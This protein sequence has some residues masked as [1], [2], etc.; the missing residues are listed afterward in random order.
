[1][2]AEKAHMENSFQYFENALRHA[3]IANDVA[4][5][6]V[7]YPYYKSNC[8]N[9][10]INSRRL[11]AESKY[12]HQD[13]AEQRRYCLTRLVDML[14]F[15]IKSSSFRS[16]L[17][18]I[19]KEDATGVMHM[20]NSCGN[21]LIED[22][23]YLSLDAPLQVLRQLL[24]KYSSLE[25]SFEDASEIFQHR[26]DD[27]ESRLDN[28]L[29]IC[30]MHGNVD[31]LRSIFSI[32]SDGNPFQVKKW[33]WS[34]GLKGI[35]YTIGHRKFR[36]SPIMAAVKGRLCDTGRPHFKLENLR[37][38]QYLLATSEFTPLINF[39]E[40]VRFVGQS[41]GEFQTPLMVAVDHRDLEA[42][43]ALLETGADPLAEAPEIC[44]SAF[45]ERIFLF[46][47][48]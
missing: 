39:P 42:V 1:M 21:L 46:S 19:S 26:S 6:S 24:T 30:A 33:G 17:F 29:S 44:M 3:V 45:H 5:M 38:L 32:V 7:I 28:I 14:S 9:P 4:V 18:L 35:F 36:S 43:D 20:K 13:K 16:L 2:C 27:N 47:L 25:I 31:C 48:R 40:I 22:A 12:A 11:P 41:K 34:L 23:Y 10:S 37:N 8:L 15:C